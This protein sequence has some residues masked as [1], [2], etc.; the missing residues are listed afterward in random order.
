MVEKSQKKL[1]QRHLRRNGELASTLIKQ[2]RS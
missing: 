1:I 2:R